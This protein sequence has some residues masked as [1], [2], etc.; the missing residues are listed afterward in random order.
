MDI[1]LIVRDLVSIH[2]TQDPYKLCKYLG[3]HVRFSKLGNIKGIYK[4]SEGY[5]FITINED[6]R[7]FERAVVLSHE[8]GHAIIHD[9][10]DTVL[11]KTAFM[12]P[13]HDKFEREA[14]IFAANLLIINN[15]IAAFEPE[16]EY[17]QGL[18]DELFNYI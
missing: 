2:E 18:Y 10:A 7:T 17:D 6:L 15:Y 8:L 11:M 12:F 4:K 3:I 13:D 14:N 1:Y 16:D 9:Y 5:K